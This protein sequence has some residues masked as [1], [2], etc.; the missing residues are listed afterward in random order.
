MYKDQPAGVVQPGGF[1][2]QGGTVNP[3]ARS[4]SPPMSPLDYADT[5]M[6]SGEHQ[7]C[8]VT[9]NSVQVCSP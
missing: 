5:L 7:E 4:T 2:M 3:S 1:G 8:F 6:Q 9:F